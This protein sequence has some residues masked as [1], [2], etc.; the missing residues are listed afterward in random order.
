MLAINPN[1]AE[2][3]YNRTCTESLQKKEKL[4]LKDLKR[5]IELNIELKED[6]KSDEDFD[7]I[8]ESEEFKRI[9]GTQD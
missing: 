2:G 1:Y 8:K 9:I 4:A 3:F 6:A 5:A 7:N